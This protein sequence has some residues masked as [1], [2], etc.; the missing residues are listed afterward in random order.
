MKISDVLRKK[1]DRVVTVR[2][3]DTVSTLLAKLAEHRIGACVVSD[4]G[5]HVDGIVS[6][7]DVVR[8]AGDVA[9]G[10]ARLP[11]RPVLI[12]SPAFPVEADRGGLV[13]ELRLAQEGRKEQDRGWRRRDPQHFVQ[14]A[15]LTSTTFPVYGLITCS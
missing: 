11:T 2:S 4:D 5:T 13:A 3:D 9:V 10:R 15:T 8:Q 1:G 14:A 6:E 12:G 7:R